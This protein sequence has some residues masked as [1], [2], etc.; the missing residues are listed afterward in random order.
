M[1]LSLFLE[2]LSLHVALPSSRL[3][4]HQR[5]QLTRFSIFRLIAATVFKIAHATVLGDGVHDS[6]RA[7][8]MNERSLPGGFGE[9]EVTGNLDP[10]DPKERLWKSNCF[11]PLVPAPLGLRGGSSL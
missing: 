9:K 2:D 7:D 6:C 3:H 1:S 11:S 4:P 10:D 5:V 8:G